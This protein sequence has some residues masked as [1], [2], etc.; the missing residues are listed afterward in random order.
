MP[1]SS[2]YYGT[3]PFSGVPV[4]NG[5]LDPMQ[6]FDVDVYVEDAATGIQVLIGGFVS[7]QYVVRNATEPYLELGQRVPRLLD[8]E[9]QFGWMMERGM[10]DARILEDTMGLKLIDRQMRVNRSPRFNIICQYKAYEMNKLDLNRANVS[11]FLISKK[12][13]IRPDG[14]TQVTV[15]G[16][17]LFNCK[18]DSLII[19]NQAGRQVVANRWEGMAEG[20]SIIYPV[21]FGIDYQEVVLEPVPYGEAA[22]T[23]Y[24]EWVSM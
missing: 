19:V 9:F 24:P 6:G 7:F 18:V 20:I 5:N 23:S 12:N 4:A 21:D 1:V 3:S 2:S 13:R 22:K 10:L 11:E 14:E 16:Y 17:K 8:G 15:A